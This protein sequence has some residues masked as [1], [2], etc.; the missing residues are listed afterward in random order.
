M[1]A[2]PYMAVGYPFQI[3]VEAP[4]AKWFDPETGEELESG[5]M[6]DIYE[7]GKP[8]FRETSLYGCGISISNL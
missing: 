1:A 4:E 3:F 2:L 7:P 6:A 5:L 8:A